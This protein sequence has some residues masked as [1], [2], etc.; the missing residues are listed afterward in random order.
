MSAALHS[1]P[2]TYL[3]A[4]FFSPDPPCAYPHLYRSAI[5]EHCRADKHGGVGY[6]A[7]HDVTLVGKPPEVPSLRLTP[8]AR[9][10]P[11]W[12]P[13]SIVPSPTVTRTLTISKIFR[14]LISS[15]FNRK[16]EVF[17]FYLHSL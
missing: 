2:L 10:W 1:L 15:V 6:G 13:C 14:A 9:V 4:V 7:M 8:V 5:E 3:C 16:Q 11:V 12:P 17:A